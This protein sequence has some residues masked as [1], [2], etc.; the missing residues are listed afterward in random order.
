MFALLISEEAW[1]NATNALLGIVV[2]ICVLAIG[3]IVFHEIANRIR[4]RA[5][6]RR[7]F[8]FDDHAVHVPQL[9]MTMADGGEPV[10]DPEARK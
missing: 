1:L 5:T 7:H 2:L 8:V 10:N 4:S 9:G 6:E 3:A